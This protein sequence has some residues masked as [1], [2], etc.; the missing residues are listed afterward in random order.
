MAPES[1]LAISEAM[2]LETHSHLT[3]FRLQTWDHGLQLLGL[4]VPWPGKGVAFIRS[5][6]PFL[7]S[8][9]P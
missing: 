1:V 4:S 2:V 9:S 5:E 3:F 8:P 6:G 7:R